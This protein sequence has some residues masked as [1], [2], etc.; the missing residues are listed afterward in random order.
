MIF[1]LSSPRIIHVH[2]ELGGKEFGYP[3]DRISPPTPLTISTPQPSVFAG[4]GCQ[5]KKVNQTE[6]H[7]IDASDPTQSPPITDSTA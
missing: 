1:V 6:F 3:G 7:I 2:W 4:K 5:S